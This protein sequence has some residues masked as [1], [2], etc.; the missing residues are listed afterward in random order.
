[1]S[2]IFISYSH[3]GNG[4]K[5]KAALLRALYVFERHHL[6]DIWQDGKIRVSALWDD[7]ITQAM[8]HAKLAVALLTKEALESQFI[9]EREL[10]LP[11]AARCG[12]TWPTSPSTAPASSSARSLTHGNPLKPTSP[13][14][15][16]SSTTAATTAATKNSPTPRKP[17]WASCKQAWHKPDD[18]STNS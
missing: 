12:C 4:P 1:M 16:N 10:P 2:R 13:P 18:W 9:I 11:S 14:P 7:D 15:R 5:W 17:S 8:N 3:H 6:L